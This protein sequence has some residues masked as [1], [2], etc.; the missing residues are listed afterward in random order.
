MSVGLSK[1]RGPDRTLVRATLAFLGPQVT[2]GSGK[3]ELEP[4]GVKNPDTAINALGEVMQVI[5]A[6]VV[7]L[8]GH[9]V[10]LDFH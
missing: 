2:Q 3:V 4:V 10:I 1:S 5:A 9:A 7:V 6:V 8:P